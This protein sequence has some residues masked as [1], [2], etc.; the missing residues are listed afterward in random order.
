MSRESRE[1]AMLLGVAYGDALGAP[2]EFHKSYASCPD[3][4]GHDWIFSKTNAYGFSVQHKVGQVTDDTEMTIACMRALTSGH[5]KNCAVA[6]YHA[7]V[8]S[9]TYCSGTNTKAIF[10]GYKRVE[11][12]HQRHSS[13]FVTQEAI[14]GARSNGHLM[15]CSPT[16]QLRNGALLVSVSSDGTRL[17]S[18]RVSCCHLRRSI[19]VSLRFVVSSPDRT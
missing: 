10:H 6:A 17:M 4:F 18:G 12:F 9:G 15:R 1:S 13:I 14:E 11:L 19:Q 2:C 16:P 8:N 5:G 3:M 7:F